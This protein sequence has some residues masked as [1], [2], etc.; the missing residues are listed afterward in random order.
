MKV[1]AIYLNWIKYLKKKGL[2]GEYMKDYVSVNEYIYFMDVKI[3]REYFPTFFEL[4]EK[5]A[6]YDPHISLLMSSVDYI[7]PRKDNSLTFNDIMYG[8]RKVRNMLR[9]PALRNWADIAT[10]FGEKN[11]YIKKIVSNLEYWSDEILTLDTVATSI[12]A[13]AQEN[14]YQPEAHWY[15]RYTRPARFNPNHDYRHRRR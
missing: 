2:Y 9:R 6:T 13:R 14:R 7:I 10:E 8:M 12:T 3:K 4:N 5:L 11:G 1:S 15:E